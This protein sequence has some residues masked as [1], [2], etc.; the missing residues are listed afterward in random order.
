MDGQSAELGLE[1]RSRDGR[2]GLIS[3]RALARATTALTDLL[4]Q[5]TSD[6]RRGDDHVDWLVRDIRAGSILLDARGVS[7]T[8]DGAA[9]ARAV[10]RD[11]VEVVDRLETER[12]IRELLSFRALERF[13]SLGGLLHL[14]VETIILRDRTTSTEAILTP[15][16]THHASALLVKRRASYGSVAGA[17]E[18]I[19]IHE[20]HPYFLVYS[21]RDGHGIKCVCDDE[22]LRLAQ[23]AFDLRATVRVTGVISRRF[24]G[25]AASVDVDRLRLLPASDDLP[26]P[27][28]VRGIE[29]VLTNGKSVQDWLRGHDG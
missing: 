23:D 25:R 29:P 22:S 27:D 15:R 16:G 3:M 20:K 5:M 21:S 14:G 2:D 12:D 6:R 1:V 19:S 17:V 18:T 10:V 11:S 8:L 26:G 7:D 4:A 13:T 9:I 24:D 28:E